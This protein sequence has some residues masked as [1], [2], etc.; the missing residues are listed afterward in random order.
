MCIG[1]EH[2][3]ILGDEK[4]TT[5]EVAK[6]QNVMVPQSEHFNGGQVAI[7]IGVQGIESPMYID[8]GNHDISIRDFLTGLQAP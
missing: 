7:Y 1:V 6:S 5:G 3:D 4:L 8:N 2:F